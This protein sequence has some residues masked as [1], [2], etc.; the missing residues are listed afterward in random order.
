MAKFQ[1]LLRRF[2]GIA[3]ILKNGA[4]LAGTQWIEVGLRGLYVL[5][6]SRWLGPELYGTWSYTT[7]TYAF[8]LGLT[9]FELESLVPLRLGRDRTAMA[10]LGTA[11]LLRLGLLALAVVGLT[12][13]ALLLGG[14]T[15]ER[16]ALILVLPALVGRGL[17]LLSRAALLGLDRSGTAFR[18]AASMRVLEVV[19]GLTSLWL[20]AGLFT[21]LVIHSA[22]WLLEAW[23]SYRALSRQTG[24]RPL[25]DRDEFRT[26]VKEGY[27]MGLATISLAFLTAMPLL[28]T[29]HLTNDLSLTGQF[30]LAT[31]IAALVVIG[32]QGLLAGALPVV[33][34]ATSRGDPRLPR[35]AAFT[36]LGT[37]VI[38]GAAYALAH[39]FGPSV[40]PVLLGAGFAPAGALLA[41]ALLVG[42]LSVLPIGAWH[43]LVASGRRWPGVVAGGLAALV[44]VWLL[45]SFVQTSGAAGAMTAAAV[46]WGVRAIVIFLSVFMPSWRARP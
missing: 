34:R 46:A 13:N 4:L 37:V 33:A 31:Q 18:F 5:A 22:V 7:T 40:V 21:L 20:G 28:L 17:V 19:A 12:V 9:L 11:I 30:G 26:L 39:R 27:V 6:I 10:F 23:L 32:A 15:L 29:R 3:S 41:P 45:P 38:F 43:I 24:V 44:L 14:D 16:V 36:A 35:Y 1:D 42:G 8:A 25:F 2:P